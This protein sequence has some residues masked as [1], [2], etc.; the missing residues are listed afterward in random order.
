MQCPPGDDSQLELQLHPRDLETFDLVPKSLSNNTY[1][2][3]LSSNFAAVDALT[4]EMVIQYTVAED[5][6]IKGPRVLD[7]LARLYPRNELVF[8][9]VVP[10]SLIAEFKK[11]PILTV[12]GT[13]PVKPPLVRQ[14]VAGLPLGISTHQLHAMS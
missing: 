4:K 1:Y 11:Q 2:V 9:F 5:H 14:Y 12:A 3:P 8:L 6:P 10:E 7:Q 13:S